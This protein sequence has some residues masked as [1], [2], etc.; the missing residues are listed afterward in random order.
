MQIFQH[1]FVDFLSSLRQKN[2]CHGWSCFLVIS[3]LILMEIRYIWSRPVIHAASTLPCVR[4][5]SFYFFNS[6]AF[7]WTYF[8]QLTKTLTLTG[9]SHLKFSKIN[10]VKKL[11][12]KKSAISKTWLFLLIKLKIKCHANIIKFL[13]LKKSW[14]WDFREI[15]ARKIN[16]HN[17]I[18]SAW[19]LF[20]FQFFHEKYQDPIF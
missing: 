10:V 7:R 20:F 19:P 5:F 6:F 12:W 17:H 2:K 1:F 3:N 18:S 13:K 4:L 14:I 16:A 9:W 11:H 8:S 15:T